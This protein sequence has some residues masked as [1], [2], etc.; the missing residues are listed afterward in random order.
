M[1]NTSLPERIVFLLNKSVASDI[2]LHKRSNGCL[3]YYISRHYNKKEALFAQHL[4]LFCDFTFLHRERAV[5]AMMWGF[6][7][8]RPG[9][10][11]SFNEKKVAFPFSFWPYFPIFA[12]EILLLWRNRSN[13]CRAGIIYKWD[14]RGTEMNCRKPDHCGKGQGRFTG[15]CQPFFCVT[16]TLG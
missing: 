5:L 11:F 13:H 8:F 6:S 12:S 9:K 2:S 1:S 10:S 14:R 4:S 15:K 3:F 16:G 7:Y